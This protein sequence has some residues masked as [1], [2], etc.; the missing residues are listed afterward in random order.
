MADKS[1]IEWTDATW[2]PIRYRVKAN[3]AEIAQAKGYTSLVNIA[4]KMAGR[5][6]P[7]CEHVSPG[8]ER[9]YSGTNN[10]RCLPSNGT[11]L[12][13]DRRARDLVEPFIDENALTLPLR[14]K[15]PR[16]I[17]VENQS[18]LFGEW[19]PDEMIDRVFAVMA[20]CP[21]HTFQVLT[22]RAARMREYCSW[23]DI[24]SRA[25]PRD[26][27]DRV[28]IAARENAAAIAFDLRDIRWPLPNV[29]LGVSCEDQQ[30]AEERIAA[31]L[32]TPAAVRFLSAE[33]LLGPLDLRRY[34]WPMCWHWDG[35]YRS[36][37]EA[38]AAGAYAELKPQALL[39]VEAANRLLGPRNGWVIVG[40]ESGPGARPC[41]I[42]WV[43]SIVEQCAAAGVACF[44]KQVGAKP[45]I[46][47]MDPNAPVFDDDLRPGF[48]SDRKGAVMEDWPADLRVRQMPGEAACRA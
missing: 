22:K 8:C 13:F 15:K 6:G 20:L 23:N 17:F 27:V 11:G 31:L 41:N 4:S 36:P 7:H 29:W 44:V 25:M 21:Q 32:Q 24:C 18:D 16:K 34:F 2:S 9:C 14:W 3:A 10:G 35:K 40:G 43:R 12:P 48:I 46:S 30:R 45:V 47:L 19:I 37:E 26:M 38:K 5:V 1:P 42:A 33:P 28:A 39:S